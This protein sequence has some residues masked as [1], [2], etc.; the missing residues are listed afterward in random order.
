MANGSIQMVDSNELIQKSFCLNKYFIKHI[1]LY[2]Y[3]IHYVKLMGNVKHKDIY[4]FFF[5]LAWKVL[6]IIIGEKTKVILLFTTGMVLQMKTLAMSIIQ[7][8]PRHTERSAETKKISCA[9]VGKQLRLL[10][11]KVILKLVR[12]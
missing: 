3:P 5:N 11:I 9:S 4:F 7:T 2:Y 6:A 12:K 1:F 8:K 10:A